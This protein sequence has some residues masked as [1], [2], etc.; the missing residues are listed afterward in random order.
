M[1]DINVHTL[2]FCLILNQCL[3]K[4]KFPNFEIETPKGVKILNPRSTKEQTIALMHKY[5][6]TATEKDIEIYKA[7]EENGS[8]Y[9][10]EFGDVVLVGKDGVTY[11]S[12]QSDIL[13][14]DTFNM[15]HS[16]WGHAKNQRGSKQKFMEANLY[17]ILSSKTKEPLKAVVVRHEDNNKVYINIPKLELHNILL[18]KPMFDYRDDMLQ[19]YPIG[20]QI[21]VF[22]ENDSKCIRVSDRNFIPDIFT[23]M[24]LYIQAQFTVYK[25]AA[26]GCICE[27]EYEG[28]KCRAYASDIDNTLRVGDVFTAPIAFN[29]SGLTAALNIDLW[30]TYS[31]IVHKAPKRKLTVYAVA[32]QGYKVYETINIGSEKKRITLFVPNRVV[33]NIDGIKVGTVLKL[34]IDEV[35]PESELVIFKI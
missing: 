7:A 31:E 29:K 10:D 6:N 3:M 15:D 8:I 9:R 30:N 28:V 5:L 35:R 1:H 24:P 20:S 27:V 17:K 18:Y 11:E 26:N 13:K 33:S 12:G 2:F 16:I 23:S 4:Q 32:S 34:E 19:M 14:D 22:I 25:T 21:Y